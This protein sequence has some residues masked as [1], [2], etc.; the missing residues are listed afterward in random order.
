MH[1]PAL[2]ADLSGVGVVQ[3]VEDVHQRRLA[4]AVA[5]DEAVD[6]AGGQLEVGV[7]QGTHRPNDLLTPDIV[8]GRSGGPESW[9]GPAAAVLLI[10]PA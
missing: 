6:L 10:R 5:A 3:P 2:D 8:S 4:G 7:D 9:R 1:L